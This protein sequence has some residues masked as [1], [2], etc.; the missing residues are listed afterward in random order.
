MQTMIPT[1]TDF[2]LHKRS[3]HYYFGTICLDFGI[4]IITCHLSTLRDDHPGTSVRDSIMA[5]KTAELEKVSR[6]RV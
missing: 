5:L 2:E 6:T 4:A 1:A 3:C